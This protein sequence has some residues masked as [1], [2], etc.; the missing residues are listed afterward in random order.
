[1]DNTKMET[2]L[3]KWNPH[4]DNPEKGKWTDTVPRIKYLDR[5]EKTMTLRHIVILTG[6]RRSGKSTLIHQLIELLIKQGVSP[7]N[8]LYLY[9]EDVEVAP[10]IAL[11]AQLLEKFYKFYLEK[12]N[13]EG[14]I[15]VFIDELQGVKD[16]N[17]WLHTYYEFNRTNLKFIISG[18]R[19]SL[20]ESEAATLLTGRT[21]YFDI[22]P[23]NFY[24]YL[25][26]HNVEIKGGKS[27][28]TIRDAN[29]ESIPTILHHLQNFL[30]EGGFPEIVLAKDQSNKRLIANTYYQDILARDIILP[31]EIRNP[32]DIEVLGLQVMADFTKTHT[33]RSLGT[34][35]NL[36]V[37]TVKTYLEYFFK[38][39]LFFESQF[40]SHKTKETQDVQRPRKLYVV[41]NG[42][43]NFN[44]ITTRPDLGQCAE[45]V[46][47][48]ELRK[49]NPAVYYW[50][51]EREID[52]VAMRPPQIYFYNSCYTDQPHEREIESMVE[53]LKE[54]KADKGTVL[55][56]NYYDKKEVEGKKVDFVPLWAWLI[57]NGKVFFKEN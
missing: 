24:E 14:K 55:T 49:N 8:T 30:Y 53:G 26:M 52:F 31:N 43:R 48:M 10:F 13:P 12:Y 4:F 40:F 6:V 57:L 22:Y 2:L 37:E 39:Y 35:R 54:F 25:L 29:F 23:L 27:I 47:Y 5:I 3:R 45:N 9:L 7:I 33:Y 15:Y 32:R 28:V 51:G 21:I 1:M 38:S 44:T 19:R 46:V 41:D 42:L 50:K 11:G 17:R 34:A 56:K 20:I 36:S 16:F 18:S